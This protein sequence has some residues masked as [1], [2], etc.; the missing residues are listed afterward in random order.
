MTAVISEP[1]A[2]PEA[3]GG[4]RN[5]EDLEKVTELE[6]FDPE[7]VDGVNFPANG[8]PPLMLKALGAAS[9][10]AGTVPAATTTEGHITAE[11]T[12][13]EPGTAAQADA[14][15]P[16]GAVKAAAGGDAV[17]AEPLGSITLPPSPADM[18]RLRTY[19]Q[20][21][22]MAEA[23]AKAAQAAQRDGEAAKADDGKKGKPA[24]LTD[25]IKKKFVSDLANVSKNPTAHVSQWLRRCNQW[26][27]KGNYPTGLSYSD[28]R[29]MAQ[30]CVNELKKRNDDS[31][32][33]MDGFP[34]A[35]GT[36]IPSAGTAEKCQAGQDALTAAAS[37]SEGH[38]TRKA[39]EPDDDTD[40]GETDGTDGGD[41]DSTAK[42]AKKP[43]GKAKGGKPFP[44]AAPPFKAKG[45]QDGEAG[46][47]KAAK[48]RTCKC[49]AF[50][51]KGSKFC[52]QCGAPAGG[53]KAAKAGKPFPA[54]AK[55]DQAIGQLKADADAALAA[56]AKDPDATTHPADVKVTEE[57]EHVKDDVD[58]AAAAQEKDEE[59]DTAAQHRTAKSADGPAYHVA[60][61]HDAT[62]AAYRLEDVTAAHP[63]VSKGIGELADPAA[64]GA[65][66]TAALMED[67]GT[68]ARS[69]D[70]PGLSAAYHCAVSMKAAAAHE[71]LLDEAMDGLRKAFAGYYPDAHP[72]PGGITPG[73]FRR[74][75]VSAGHA[76]QA[77]KP[78]QE[79]RIPLASHVP[80]PDDF[81]RPLITAGREASSPGSK[82]SGVG[83]GRMYYSNAGKDQAATV[84][85]A[86]HDYIADTHP[87]ICPMKGT[88]PDNEPADPNTMAS[89]LTTAQPA[90]EQFAATKDKAVP[91]SVG[92]GQ[93]AA[94][95]TPGPAKKNKTAKEE[96]KMAKA[97][98]RA[99]E[100]A[101]AAAAQAPLIDPELLKSTLREIVA[102]PLG[103]ITK[104]IGSFEERLAAMESAPDPAQ[105]T[106]RS[107]AAAVA[108]A[109]EAGPEVPAGGDGPGQE[110][111][112]RLMKKTMDPD[113]GVRVAAIGELTELV[114]R[115][116]AAELLAAA[117]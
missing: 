39:A 65:M 114:G 23:A 10:Q 81:R 115:E 37:D 17:T 94:V 67:A 82:P 28:V 40:G 15:P 1:Q 55:V 35:K 63:A 6:A 21:L 62:C 101:V 19:R 71:G 60:R 64:F 5:D 41:G 77:A 80:S 96:R 46:D 112:M 105:M 30:Q 33:S 26:A 2:G 110:R 83:K 57:L 84:L 69:A 92:A 38:D 51:A 95:V 70:L 87:S 8:F 104:T 86:M 100:A 18:A 47:G 12:T 43:K 99:E 9:D 45:A 102:G 56:Q 73:E 22:V 103:D 11:P 68:G 75:Y 78:G 85:A 58:A 91:V 13:P 48:G 49:G 74:P 32:A 66:V 31:E 113:G 109:R 107:G 111:L 36:G 25:A 7:R 24:G 4:D 76:S 53:K 27:A 3:P 29:W 79:P 72:K 20:Q 97:A 117:T 34:A 59:T 106:P 52:S 61:L 89:T 93:A 108:K 98:K 16:A 42:A 44:G 50:M 14:G 116:T 90:P 88:T 54:D